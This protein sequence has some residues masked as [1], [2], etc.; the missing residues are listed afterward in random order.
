MIKT[1]VPATQRGWTFLRP[2]ATKIHPIETA[3]NIVAKVMPG[4]NTERAVTMVSFKYK[5]N[6]IQTPVDRPVLIAAVMKGPKDGRV[7]SGM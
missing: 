7:G 5:P 1:A 2:S 6:V 3:I 4:I